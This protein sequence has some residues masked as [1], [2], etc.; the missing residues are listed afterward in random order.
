M[1]GCEEL[2]AGSAGLA[3]LAPTDP[4]RVA[5]WEHAR[6]CA[7][8]AAALRE[9]EALLQLIDA[10]LPAADLSP[11]TLRRLET[12]VMTAIEAEAT[13]DGLPRWRPALAAVVLGTF[14]LLTLLSRNRAMDPPS[15]WAAA[16]AA[17]LAAAVAGFARK[18]V[19]PAVGLGLGSLIFALWA[20][21]GTGLIPLVGLKCL[22]I[23]LAAAAVPFAIAALSRGALPR[24]ASPG[25]AAAVAA[26]AALGGQAAL[27]LTCPAAHQLPHLLAFHVMGVALAALIGARWLGLKKAALA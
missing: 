1:T 14:L 20:G 17:I 15:L 8:C 5:A 7:G 21:T 6:S 23:E 18:G 3:A 9:G 11:A 26:A 25:P 10:G 27:H 16:I 24:P 12:A 13:A 19:S 2:R 22:A 4:E